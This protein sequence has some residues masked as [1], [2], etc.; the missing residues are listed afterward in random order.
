M[1]C[2]VCKKDYSPTC[3]YNQGRCPNHPAVVENILNDGY[4]AR[5][6]HLYHTIKA[7]VRKLFKK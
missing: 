1:K 2:N 6:Y 4:R 5:Y 3:D 7:T